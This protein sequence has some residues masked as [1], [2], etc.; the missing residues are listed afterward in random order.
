MGF[1]SAAPISERP[2]SREARMLHAQRI[3]NVTEKA[4][5]GGD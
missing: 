4:I 2:T 3:V 5:V 1:V